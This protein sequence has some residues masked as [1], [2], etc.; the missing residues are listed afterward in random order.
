MIT[1]LEILMT[2]FGLTAVII[3]LLVLMM[4]RQLIAMVDDRSDKLLARQD[5]DRTV[6]NAR[7]DEVLK[8]A[9]DQILDRR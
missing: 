8:P 9:V 1:I 6:L 5:S 7:I 3:C 4:M 2:M